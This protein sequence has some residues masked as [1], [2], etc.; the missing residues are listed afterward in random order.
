MPGTETIPNRLCTLARKLILERHDS[1]IRLSEVV[2]FVSGSPQF[3]ITRAFDGEAEAPLYT[4][5]GQLDMEDDLVDLISNVEHK[6]VRTYD[7]VNTLFAGDVL[8]SLISGTSTIVR[9][10]HE[11][12][13]YTQN[14]V[15]LIPNEKIEA[16]YLVYLLNENQLIKKQF[17]MGLQGS[18]VLKY[19]LKQ[20]RELKLPELPSIQKQQTIGDLYFNQ[21]RLQALRY[22]AA[23]SETT[24]LLVKLE[25]AS[26]HE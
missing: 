25:G 11:G 14:F 7:E 24:I 4:Y 1:M 5:Y 26:K 17:L 2:K 22:R 3:R 8:F 15:K 16:K 9:K 18:Q 20:V 12:Y 10:E 6:T 19:T 23:K 21:L 13:L